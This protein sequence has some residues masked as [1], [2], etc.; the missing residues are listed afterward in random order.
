MADRVRNR[1]GVNRILEKL[2]KG[3][4][5]LI[6]K[7]A[8]EACHNTGIEAKG[9]FILGNPGETKETLEETKKFILS[10]PLTYV[11]TT[12]FTPLPGS[13]AFAAATSSVL[14]NTETIGKNWVGNN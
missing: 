7:K 1:I 2:Q 12:F 13:E 9:Y 6:L 3:E 8:I 4:T 5:T 11:H 10:T 14:L